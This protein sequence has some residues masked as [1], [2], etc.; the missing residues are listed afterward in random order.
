MK[1]D[2]RQSKPEGDEIDFSTS[3]EDLELNIEGAGFPEPIEGQL[4]LNRSGDEII[5]DG[6]VS[7]MV[8]LECSRCLE[9]F[10]EAIN[11]RMR[12]VIQM[13]ETVDP[14]DSNDED[15]IILPK[16]VS[17]YDISE[18]VR[19]ALILEMPLKPLCSENCQGLCPMCGVNL[20]EGECDCT[21]DKTDERWDALKQLFD[22]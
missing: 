1:I 19:E 22:E 5:V 13:L 15:F 12:F 2:L 14:Q 7:T 6:R 16:T 3:A 20:N 21:P 17:E 11:A 18:R 9:V 8:E 10:D 4:Q